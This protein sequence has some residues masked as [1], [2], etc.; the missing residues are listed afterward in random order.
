MIIPATISWLISTI[1]LNL[2]L[3][4]S[5]N[6]LTS[7]NID[8][9]KSGLVLGVHEYQSASEVMVEQ[10]N[11]FSQAV[12]G[13]INDAKSLPIPPI[14]QLPQFDIP[15]KRL[16]ENPAKEIVEPTVEFELAA[17]NGA[18]LDCQN[19]N[20][21][22]AKKPDRPGLSLVSQI[23]TAYTFLIIILAGIKFMK[24]KPWINARRKNL[25]IYW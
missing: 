24:L 8:S 5:G 2:G 1:F 3:A 18:I 11:N 20:L 25:L 21:F 13:V 19:N 15:M 14:P 7:L 6:F 22:F 4:F 23:F 16:P 17:E 10:S 9:I 12:A